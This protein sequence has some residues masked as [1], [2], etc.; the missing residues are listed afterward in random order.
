[1][2]AKILGKLKGLIAS[3]KESSRNGRKYTEAFWDN[4]FDS[5]FFQEGIKNRVYF[6]ELW[7]PDNEDDYGQI[8]P[9]DRAAIV[10]TKVEKDGLDY[11][12]TF[13]ILPTRA[14]EVLK[15]LYDVGCKLGISSRGYSDKERTVFDEYSDYEFITFDIV[16]FPGI[17]SARLSMVGAVAESFGVRK[18]NKAKIMENLSNIVKENKEYAPM[19]KKSLSYK[20]KE[21]FDDELQVEDLVHMYP[22]LFDEIA[23]DGEDYDMFI[24][25][26]DN[27]LK[28]FNVTD[29]NQV[30]CDS[31]VL[32][33]IAD[34]KPHDL[35]AV[36]NLYW[37][38]EKQKYIAVGSWT[39]LEKEED[40]NS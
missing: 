38:N 31:K 4:I 28:P 23:I 20:A 11:Y 8:H 14:G 17:K 37:S 35:F 1:M 18:T 7:H 22:D 19:I 34:A 40:K 21:G 25:E 3:A 26:L 24:V 15:N 27:R 29:G 10:L 30:Y 13:D 33:I 5:E 36:D 2:K 32:S 12:G 9:G 6:G 39:K 16:A